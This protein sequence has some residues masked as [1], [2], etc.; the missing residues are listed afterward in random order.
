VPPAEQAQDGCPKLRI[1][2][3]S[4]LAIKH[5]EGGE[6]AWQPAEKSKNIR[7]QR[8]I[9]PVLVWKMSHIFN[10]LLDD[11]LIET[12]ITGVPALIFNTRRFRRPFSS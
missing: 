11:F 6:M 8:R 1:H 5:R 3:S 9:F 7:H 4:G 2:A 10:G 12:R